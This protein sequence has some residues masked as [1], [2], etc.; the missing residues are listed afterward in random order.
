MHQLSI[1]LCVAVVAIASASYY[2]QRAPAYHPHI[3]VPTPGH[4]VSKCILPTSQK[5]QF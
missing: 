5:F 2:P 4:T 3:P 1:V